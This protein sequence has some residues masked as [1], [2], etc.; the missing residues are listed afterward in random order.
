MKRFL[1]ILCILTALAA[2]VSCSSYRNIRISEFRINSVSAK[3]IRNIE[4]SA[5]AYAVN[6]SPATFTM[7]V[8]A[9]LMIGENVFAEITS[10]DIDKL[11][12]RSEG[13]V[14]GTFNVDIKD[15]LKLL[16]MGLNAEKWD[17][18]LFTVSGTALVK[19]SNGIQK[20]LKMKNLPLD[21]FVKGLSLTK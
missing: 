17:I 20:K 11:K 9:E 3:S 4:V 12:S 10:I 5:S 7:E 18:N 2:T 13:T 1:H 19:G 15:P 14:S 21:K 16:S 8:D 6:P